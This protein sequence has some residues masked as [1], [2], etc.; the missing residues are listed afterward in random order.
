VIKLDTSKLIAKFK[1]LK[2]NREKSEE[3][4]AEVKD[5]Q[6]ISLRRMRQIQLN[7]LEKQRLRKQ[8]HSYNFNKNRREVWGIDDKNKNKKT[9]LASKYNKKSGLLCEKKPLLK[10]KNRFI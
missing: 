2:K 3:L 5:K 7:E 6:L 9:N 8:I 1:Q 4:S 10:Q